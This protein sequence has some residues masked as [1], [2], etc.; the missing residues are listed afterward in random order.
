M[1]F[2]LKPGERAVT[3]RYTAEEIYSTKRGEVESAIIETTRSALKTKDIK[4]KDLPIRSIS[5]PDK[6]KQAIE[7]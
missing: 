3:G 6:I 2:V 7:S 1:F 4:M 5:L